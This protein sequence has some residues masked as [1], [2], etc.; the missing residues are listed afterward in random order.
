MSSCVW[1]GSN[2][3]KFDEIYIIISIDLLEP[4]STKPTLFRNR[5]AAE[6]SDKAKVPNSSN[7]TITSTMSM[8]TMAEKEQE[9]TKINH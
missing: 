7:K 3:V 5:M 6:K 4:E 1:F 2:F 9:V 8:M